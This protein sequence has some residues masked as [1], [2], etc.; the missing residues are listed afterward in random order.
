MKPYLKK[1]I[2]HLSHSLT[3]RLEKGSR[4]AETV[5]ICFYIPNF[6]FND[7]SFQGISSNTQTFVLSFF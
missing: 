5:S 4:E 3:F 1:E 7:Y 2:I 6:P